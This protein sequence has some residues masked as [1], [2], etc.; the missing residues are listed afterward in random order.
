[1]LKI[2]DPGGVTDGWWN[3]RRPQQGVNEVQSK[4]LRGLDNP[5]IVVSETKPIPQTNRRPDQ[6]DPSRQ[7]IVKRIFK[8]GQ[9]CKERSFHPPA[10]EKEQLESRP[11]FL[12]QSG[13]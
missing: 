13:K 10:A 9:V 2:R 3:G 1:M 7:S 5:G 8:I 11:F 12:R 4:P 6:T